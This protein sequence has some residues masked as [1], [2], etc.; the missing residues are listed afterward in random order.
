MR[1]LRT[2][3]ERDPHC[4]FARIPGKPQSAVAFEL[5]HLCGRVDYIVGQFD[6]FPPISLWK[7]K[8]AK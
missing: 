2:M 3:K 8:N 7:K 1:C 5:T 4:R 6:V